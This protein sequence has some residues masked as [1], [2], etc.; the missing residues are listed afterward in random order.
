MNNRSHK[1]LTTFNWTIRKKLLLFCLSLLLIPT[2]ILSINSYTAA[3]SETDA[4]IRKNLENSVTL[5]VENMKAY[6]GMV[7]GGQ[8]TLE[9]AQDDMK[10]AMLGDRNGDGTRPINRKIDLGENGY[11]YVISDKGDLL[12]HPKLE[13]ENL[14][15]SK[16]SDGYYYIQDV[17]KQGINGGGYTYYD[18]PLPNSDKEALKIT[19]ALQMPEW[20]WIVVA[21]SYYQDY[22]EGQTRILYSMLT[23]LALCVIVGAAGVWL[24]S[25]HISQP[26]KRIAESAR[27]VAAGELSLDGLRI[28]NRDEIGELAKDFNT[29]NGNIVA[30]VGQVANN[31]DNVSAASRALQSSI[32]ETTQASRQIAESTQRITS[33]IETQAAST[34]QSSRAME[35][36]ARGIGQIA[37]TST[38]AHET[39]ISSKLEAEQGY[40]VLQSSIAKMGT[41]EDAIIGISKVMDTLNERSAE[42]GG[43]V[44]AMTEIASQTSL[45]SLNASIEA[46]R[47]GE[48]GKGFAVVALEVK[49]LAELSRSS[50]E[51]IQALVGQVQADIATASE[52]T[53]TGLDEFKQGLTAMEAGGRSF[54]GIVEAS[55]QVVEQIQESSAAAEEMS[56]STEE[57]YASLQELDRLAGR[58][59]ENSET[60]SAATEEQIAVM[61][62]IAHSSRSLSEM[63]EELKEAA[64]RFRI[65]S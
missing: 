19:Y 32:D 5:M 26:I 4:L 21:G 17:I 37:A 65:G 57:I 47:A 49:K 23:T 2:L 12:A 63:A 40:E 61:E 43:I 50:S 58:S 6:Q 42:I 59:A 1:I 31:A 18:W 36:M 9:D 53:G 51:Q 56:A 55:R 64:H 8:L 41:V 20:D 24:F 15:E 14:W 13:G 38:A 45:L 46:A 52:A 34:E 27:R 10:A 3:K 28:K 33:G 7:A 44:T 30:L 35:D 25:N 39:S 54:A 62:Q 16:T 22:N 48:Q 60:I 29:M 11:Y